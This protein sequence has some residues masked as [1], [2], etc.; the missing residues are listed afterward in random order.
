M[1]SSNSFSISFWLKKTAKKN[2]GRI[3]IYARIRFEG[4]YSDL[5]VHRSI[6]EERWWLMGIRVPL[7]T[8]M[9]TAFS[10]N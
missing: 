7:V 10:R 1:N 4:R 5:S 3:P 6:L 9:L 2:D 8:G